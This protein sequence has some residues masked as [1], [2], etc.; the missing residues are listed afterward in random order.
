MYWNRG[1][2]STLRN[3]SNYWALEGRVWG[4]QNVV[5]QMTRDQGKFLAIRDGT[6]ITE[7]FGSERATPWGE[8]F[9]HS[10]SLPFYQAHLDQLERI[11]DNFDMYYRNLLEK[12][13]R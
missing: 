10:M 12:E 11:E 13:V 8:R 7:I 5:R 9:E 4:E 3:E 1:L 2:R 6:N